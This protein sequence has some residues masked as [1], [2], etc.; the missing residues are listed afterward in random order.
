MKPLRDGFSRQ[1][2][3]RADRVV[4]YTLFV[5][6]LTLMFIVPWKTVKAQDECPT[7]KTS[8]QTDSSACISFCGD[9]TLTPRFNEATHECVCKACPPQGSDCDRLNAALSCDGGQR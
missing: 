4:V 2:T 9:P 8:T 3:V 6:I 5:L 7:A 1:L